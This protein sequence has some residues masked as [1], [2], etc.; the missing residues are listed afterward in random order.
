MRRFL[1]IF[2]TISL[3]L[4]AG[5]PLDELITL[6]G[7][8]PQEWV[9]RGKERWEFETLGEDKREEILPLLK[10]LGFID[11]VDAAEKEYDYAVVHGSLYSTIK[12]RIAHLALQYQH[13]VRFREIVLLTG[14]RLLE[15]TKLEKDLPFDTETEMVLYAWETA[16]LPDGMRKL[17]LTVIDAKMQNGRPTTKD[18]LLEWLKSH[19]VPGRCLMISNQPYV[20]YQDALA[21]AYLPSDFIIETIGDQADE[22]MP[23]S[24]HLDNI[25]RFLW[26]KNGR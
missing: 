14:Q 15:K 12:K 25:G 5:E 16:D 26:V 7:T 10:R 17:P 6:V 9:Q 8:P 4:F 13:G 3:Q 24:V 11:A 2:L 23:M 22:N 20:Q 19:P 18:T 1:L 21:K